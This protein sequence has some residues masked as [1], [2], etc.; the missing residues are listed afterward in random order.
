[1]QGRESLR[2]FISDGGVEMAKEKE[3]KISQ[4]GEHLYDVLTL[5]VLGPLQRTIELWDANNCGETKETVA[6]LYGMRDA[7]ILAHENV[8][9][10]CDVIERDIGKLQ[11]D[12]PWGKS[13]LDRRTYEKAFIVEGSEVAQ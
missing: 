10:I 6:A 2:L 13:F 5:E 1:M 7:Y 12:A 9:A 3:E 11:I 8:E 4:Y